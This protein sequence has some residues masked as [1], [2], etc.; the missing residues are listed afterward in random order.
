MSNIRSIK[1][2]ILRNSGRLMVRDGY[3]VTPDG[4]KLPHFRALKSWAMT[5]KGTGFSLGQ[6]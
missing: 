4:K 6:V 5:I 1:R 2:S 3:T